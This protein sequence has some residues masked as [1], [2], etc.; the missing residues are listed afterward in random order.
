MLDGY[1]DAYMVDD[2]NFKKSTFEH[3]MIFTQ[4]A[5]Y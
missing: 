1:T 5:V 3:L 4:E 2:I